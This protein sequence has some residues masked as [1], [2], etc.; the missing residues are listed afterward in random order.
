MDL[1]ENAHLQYYFL[2]LTVQLN[3]L[4]PEMEGY[5]PRTDSRYRKDLRYFEEDR[6]EE[7][8]DQKEKTEMRQRRV[9]EFRK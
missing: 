4:T 6:I 7:S 9:R 5:V 2:P 8:E 1:V 3:A